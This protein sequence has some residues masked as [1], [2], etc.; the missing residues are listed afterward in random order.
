M[1]AERW[2]LDTNILV[3]AVDRDA[4]EKHR[5]AVELLDALTEQD[6][7][8][9]LQA[10]AE[11]FHVVTRKGHVPTVEAAGIVNDWSILFPVIA[12]G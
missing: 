10:L 12:A 4:G 2:S 11:F 7:V 1:T 9:S 5:I 3:Y 8:L 6:C